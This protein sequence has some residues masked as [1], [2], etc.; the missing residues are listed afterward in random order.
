MKRRREA[1]NYRV[2][3]AI[4]LLIS[5]AAAARP[6]SG[7]DFRGRLAL[8]EKA[9]LSEAFR[10]VAVKA[11]RP[12]PWGVFVRDR[13][14]LLKGN[15]DVGGGDLGE[16]ADA[17]IWLAILDQDYR[18]N[19][20]LIYVEGGPIPGL[21]EDRWLS[22]NEFEADVMP[23][24]VHHPESF[25]GG[26]VERAVRDL[27]SRATALH[28]LSWYG[29]LLVPGPEATGWR[30][31]NPEDPL[32]RRVRDVDHAY[33]L[34]NAGAMR[35]TASVLGADLKMLPGYPARAKLALEIYLN[36]FALMK[37]GLALYV[38][39]ALMFILRAA[40]GGRRFADAGAWAAG[41]GFVLA[42]ATLVGRS[43]IAAHLPIAGGYEIFSLLS[44]SVIL[45]FIVFY[46]TTRETFLGLALP[47][48]AAAIAGAA[49]L[50]PPQIETPL[51]PAL[52]SW[53]FAAHVAL[54]VIGGGAF[55]VGFAAASARLFQS[56]PAGNRTAFQGRIWEIESRAFAVGYPLVALG[57]LVAGAIRAQKAWGAWW[58]WGAK[59][60]VWL[61]P[62]ALATV[63]LH[64]GRKAWKGRVGAVLAFLTFAAVVGALVGSA[65]SRVSDLGSFY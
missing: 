65:V 37:V 13:Y 30:A 34:K 36:K 2:L 3:C 39:S 50:F 33:A 31:L 11:D 52:R 24:A 4:T 22:L 28:R 19:A 14:R 10:G 51:A 45:F 12:M 38:A 9:R 59:D 49:L 41:A 53:W 64:I 16:N 20:R 29:L 44:W 27:V 25:G 60:A 61:V 6:E 47:A 7:G 32:W 18:R 17:A 23:A 48:L 15:G 46:L 1:M 8:I 63:Y 40:F 35:R 62:L 56:K 55:A 57:V 42:T 5:T 43:V 26:D 58:H 21:A 54:P